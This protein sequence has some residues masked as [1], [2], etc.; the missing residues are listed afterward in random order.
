MRHGAAM[1]RARWLWLLLAVVGAAVQA[2]PAAAG[3]RTM[4]LRAGPFTLGGFET[5]TPKT[6][7]RTPGVD[8]F[9][10]H[11]DARLVRADGRRVPISRVMLHH[12]VFLNSSS[13]AARN[14]TSCGGRAGQPFWGTG[15]ER[16]KLLLPPGYGYRLRARDRWLMQTMLMSH[17]LRGQRVYVEYRVRVVTGR[18]MTPV[19]PLWLRANGCTRHPSYD[20]FGD[21]GPGS[22]HRR[23]HTWRM[24]LSGRIVA[25][26]AH[27]HGSSTGMTLTQPRC[28][29]RT[30]VEHRSRYANATDPVYRLRP[31]LHEPGPIATGYFLS[32]S[33][34]PVER[35]EP[36]RVTGLYGNDRPHPQVMAISHVYVAPGRAKNRRC[37]PLPAD[38]RIHWTRTDGGLVPPAVTVPLNGLD[39]QGRV[40]EIDRP[41]GAEQVAG[42][43][44]IVRLRGSRFT[45]ANLS[46]ARGATV[47]WRWEDAARHN[48]LLASGPRNVSSSTRGRGAAYVRTFDT[49]GT[50]KLFCYLHPVTMQQ[51]VTV[52][53]GT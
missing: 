52:R 21:G 25:A 30:L 29:G 22:V 10:T 37:A 32:R 18:R 51:V 48:V 19:R 8:G 3:T 50:Y 33:G 23:A 6:W 26:G 45:P 41:A 4:T 7:V 36:L 1:A 47:S 17:S 20:V 44:A 27:L 38:R 40:V 13:S 2:A 46:V 28:G 42:N 16:Q 5:R 39:P 12:I 15:E 35:G 11:M 31:V 24:P 14:R 53:P 9:L 34:I 49:P 43:R